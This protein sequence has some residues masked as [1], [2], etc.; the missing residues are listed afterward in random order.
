MNCRNCAGGCIHYKF[1]HTYKTIE[2]KNLNGE[3]QFLESFN[4][5]H[6][7]CDKNPNGYN[8]WQEQH[9]NDTYEVYKDSVM[10]CYE[11]DEQTTSVNK[12]MELIEEQLK[13]V[14]KEKK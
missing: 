9:K 13:H 10:E 5:Y 2:H 6:H 8:E 11:P 14:K 12:L 4:G 3:V 1:E 7:F